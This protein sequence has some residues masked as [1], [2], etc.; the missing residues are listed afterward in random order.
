MDRKGGV[1]RGGKGWV[2]AKSGGDGWS[3]GVVK[4]LL[5]MGSA[6]GGRVVGLGIGLGGGGTRAEG[7]GMR[8]GRVCAGG[9]GEVLGV[10]GWDF[11]WI[12]AD[13]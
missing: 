1:G 2:S 6:E 11:A 9:L 7:S 3:G 5:A 10:G 4:D 8:D 13:C 12:E